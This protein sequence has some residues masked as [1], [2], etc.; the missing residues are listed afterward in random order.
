M[1]LIA[2]QSAKKVADLSALAG[3][4]SAIVA[5]VARALSPEPEQRWPGARAMRE[6][7]DTE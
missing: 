7:L 5:L 2:K 6:A 3:A 1:A 4:P